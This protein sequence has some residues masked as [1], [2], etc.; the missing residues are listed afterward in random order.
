MAGKKKNHGDNI[1][2][3]SLSVLFIILVF[4]PHSYA[5]DRSAHRIG[6][7]SSYKSYSLNYITSS[8]KHING[9]DELSL[10]MDCYGLY[11]DAISSPG[12]K[13][14]YSHNTII[15]RIV[16][17]EEIAYIVYAGAGG[18]IGY[19]KDYSELP[20]NYGGIVGLSTKIGSI[21]AFR[22]SNF[23]IGLSFTAE[24]AL[25]LRR[26]EESHGK[27]GLSWYANGLIW[28]FVPQI[29]IFRRF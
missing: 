27:L 23:E 28:A 17:N 24:W 19:V 16:L 14:D 2:R 11:N 26:M 13:L 29:S 12:F 25:H 21:V 9:F 5:E 15:K 7:V 10:I 22:N 1:C 18:L 3:L 8:P 6:I 4:A 20:R